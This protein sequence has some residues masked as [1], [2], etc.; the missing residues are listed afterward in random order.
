MRNTNRGANRLHAGCTPTGAA[1][2]SHLHIKEYG[3]PQ[4]PDDLT[5]HRAVYNFSAQTRR[6]NELC[7]VNDAGLFSVSVSGQAAANETGLY[8]KMSLEG[9]GL[10]QLAESLVAEHLR[11]GLWVKVLTEWQ[12]PSACFILISAFFLLPYAHL[13]TGSTSFSRMK[14][15]GRLIRRTNIAFQPI[16]SKGKE[17]EDPP[18]TQ[19]G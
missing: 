13:L 14:F 17:A 15:T 1:S 16:E 4:S 7:F 5:Q 11:K 18:G 2:L 3:V 8:I 10:V 19:N 9:F 6:A 12:P